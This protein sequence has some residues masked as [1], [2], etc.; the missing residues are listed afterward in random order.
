M[1]AKPPRRVE[2]KKTKRKQHRKPYNPYLPLL[3]VVLMSSKKKQVVGTMHPPPRRGPGKDQDKKRN[4]AQSLKGSENH[5]I[6][7]QSKTPNKRP[8]QKPFCRNVSEETPNPD[9]FEV[10]KAGWRGPWAAPPSSEEL[11]QE[12]L[13]P[14]GFAA[15]PSRVRS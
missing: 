2:N 13:I 5:I 12:T 4:K 14:R 8:R 6:F 3:S 9:S 1:G 7:P 15:P 10:N 11:P